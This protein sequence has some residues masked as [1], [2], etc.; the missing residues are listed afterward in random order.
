MP[1]LLRTPF[2]R[3][4]LP[5]TPPHSL[6]LPPSPSLSLSRPPTPSPSLRSLPTLPALLS[7]WIAEENRH[8]DVLNKYLY[9]SGRVDMRAVER[10]VQ[11]VRCVCV[12][13]CVW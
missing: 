9:L 11:Q 7:K 13:E 5:L 2:I 10:T 6:P 4:W 8:G 3:L 1:P 12:G